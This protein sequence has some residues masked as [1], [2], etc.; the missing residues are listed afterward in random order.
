MGQWSVGGGCWHLESLVSS[1]RAAFWCD[2][3]ALV[4]FPCSFDITAKVSKVVGSR[5]RWQRS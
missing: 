2:V 3:H 5:E 4:M 1:I